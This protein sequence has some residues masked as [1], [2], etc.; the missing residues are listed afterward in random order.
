MRL[1]ILACKPDAQTATE[2]R[3]GNDIM[4]TKII[5]RFTDYIDK[6][7]DVIVKEEFEK[8]LKSHTAASIEKEVFGPRG[9]PD[10]II[11]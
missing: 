5:K 6:R 1:Y 10:K 8:A 9:K 11:T 4:I 2:K 7:L 3:K